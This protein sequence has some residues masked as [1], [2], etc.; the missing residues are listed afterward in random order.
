MAPFIMLCRVILP[1]ASL[2]QMLRC[3]Y[4]TETSAFLSHASFC[5]LVLYKM[6]LEIFREFCVP[7]TL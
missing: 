4:S 2:N 5:C 3:D 7:E 6:K 1:Y